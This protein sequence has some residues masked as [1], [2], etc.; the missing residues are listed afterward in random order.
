M[1]KPTLAA[2]ISL[3]LG[4]VAAHAEPGSDTPAPAA[5]Q[6]E[7]ANPSPSTPQAEPA[8]ARAEQNVGTEP[9][10]AD[11]K[12]SSGAYYPYSAGTVGDDPAEPKST[13]VPT[14]ATQK[15]TDAWEVA[16]TDG[17][18]HLSQAELAKVAPAAAGNFAGADVDG[19]KKLSR[20]ELRTWRESQ[21]ATMDADQGGTNESETW[22]DQAT[23]R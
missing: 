3:L 14:G 2:A 21:K 7:T 22:M 20:D 10:N 12:S 23:Q 16:D 18:D 15:S 13:A 6:T 17:D 11:E 4:V 5:S 8:K 19:D 1:Y 9:S